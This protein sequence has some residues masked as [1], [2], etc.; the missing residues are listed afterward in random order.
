MKIRT[1]VNLLINLKKLAVI[2]EDIGKLSLSQETEAKSEASPK[3]SKD[4][5]K[6]SGGTCR[7][8]RS[9]EARSSVY[10]TLNKRP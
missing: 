1:K 5:N 9:E 3:H 8:F 4:G 6:Q 7:G 10:F 2:F